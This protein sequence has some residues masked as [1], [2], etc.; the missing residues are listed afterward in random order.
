[1]VDDIIDIDIIAPI[2]GLF[3][4]VLIATGISQLFQPPVPEPPTPPQPMPDK[5][6]LYGVVIDAITGNA[7]TGVLVSLNGIQTYTNNNGYYILADLELGEYTL[8]FSKE[9]YET[10]VC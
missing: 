5:A 7:I 3:G 9:G 6:N 1:M 8:E 10:L 2:V 4:V